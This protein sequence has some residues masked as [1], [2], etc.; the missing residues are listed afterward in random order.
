[1][2]DAGEYC[3]QIEHYLCRR[4]EGHLIRLV[5]PR[6]DLVQGWFN[7]GIPLKLALQGI[8][9]GVERRRS[10][11]SRPRPV[12]IEFCEDDVLDVFD[13]WRRSVGVSASDASSVEA[14]GPRSSLPAHLERVIARLTTLRGAADRTL[15]V[16]LDTIVRELDAARAKAKSIRGDARDALIDR[17][18]QL[19]TSLIDALREQA[20]Q[21]MLRQL[22]AEADEELK[23]FRARMPAEEYAR[24]HR[25]CIDR[26][27][28]DRA[29]LPGISYE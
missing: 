3:R 9:R 26:L 29:G 2:T 6:F 15:D 12:P 7:R 25:A 22:A 4:N 21:T 1:V 18:R 14:E 11:D 17:L 20:D 19:D 16:V 13:E 24:S 10:K 8:D 28:R 23:P 5:G 27:L